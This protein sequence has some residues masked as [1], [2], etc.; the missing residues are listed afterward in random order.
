MG[1]RLPKSE[2][3]EEIRLERQAL[4]KLLRELKPRQMTRGEVTAAGWSVKDILG[5]LVSWQQMNLDWY[6]AG[7]R[8]H[9][10]A[11]P[12]PG[13]TWKDLRKLNAMIYRKHHRRSL[14]AVLND[15]ETFHRRML[16][17]I[18]KVPDSDLVRVGR[19]SWA[20]PTWSLSEYIRA[21]TASHYRWAC[22]HIRI[23]LRARH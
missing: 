2:L 9:N 18:Q 21:N 8:G 6:E 17:L 7:E 20:G 19:F 3:L 22:K 14:R 13:L 16:E 11:V 4:D 10:P 1:K 23:R 5:H 12:A 15:Y